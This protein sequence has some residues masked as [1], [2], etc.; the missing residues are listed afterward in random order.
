VIPLD[1]QNHWI[2]TRLAR[3]ATLY[4]LFIVVPLASIVLGALLDSRRLMTV[5][6]LMQILSMGLMLLRRRFLEREY[7]R[8]ASGHCMN[9]GYDLRASR[10]RC[11]ECGT[12]IAQDKQINDRST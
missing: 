5:G 1:E 7:D 3:P 11:P 8:L 12:A 9:C 4:F 6:L 2:K 10:D